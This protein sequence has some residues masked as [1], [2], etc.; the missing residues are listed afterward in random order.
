MKLSHRFLLLFVVLFTSSILFSQGYK[1]TLTNKS[2]IELRKNNLGV[3]I[4]KMK[5]TKSF[6]AFDLSVDGLIQLKKNGISDEIIT[7]M[8]TYQTGGENSANIVNSNQG[9]RFAS[10]QTSSNSS[11][12]SKTSEKNNLKSTRPG[13]Y[14]CIGSAPEL[15]QL[16]TSVFSRTK[17]GSGLATGYTQGIAKKKEK[18]LLN[19]SSSSFQIEEKSPVFRFY[20]GEGRDDFAT[21]AN[22]AWFSSASN[23]N[24]FLLI[25]FDVKNGTREIITGSSNLYS[26]SSTGVDNSNRVAFKFQKIEEGVYKIFFDKPLPKGEYCFMYAGGTNASTAIINKV[27]DFSIK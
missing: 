20:F 1:D 23:P 15:I 14:Y 9:N 17:S 24:E 7:S 2:I 22:F 18:S 4:I 27:Y 19:G 3:D 13:I 26:G 6:C 5:I 12:D 10:N 8:L 11:N 25:R 21:S 16:E